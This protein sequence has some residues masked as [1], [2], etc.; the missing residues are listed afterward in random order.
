[1]II[2]L[3]ALFSL[4]QFA[5][6]LRI[7]FVADQAEVFDVSL[8]KLILMQALFISLCSYIGYKSIMKKTNWY[9]YLCINYIIF[10]LIFTICYKTDTYNVIMAESLFYIISSFTFGMMV[11]CGATFISKC[12]D[13]NNRYIGFQIGAFLVIIMVC[14][15]ISFFAE[16]FAYDFL[17]INL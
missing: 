8:L 17:R 6:Y 13:L 11:L 4:M 5:R 16:T 7:G 2:K 12:I 9:K 15:R 14:W 10:V 1:M 3:V